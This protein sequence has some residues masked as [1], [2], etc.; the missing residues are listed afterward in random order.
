MLDE[1]DLNLKLMAM[2]LLAEGTAQTIFD[3]LADAKIEPVL[4]DL[5]P[6]IE[7]D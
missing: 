1:Q 2:Q 7:R 3:F 4:S 5:L 6:Y